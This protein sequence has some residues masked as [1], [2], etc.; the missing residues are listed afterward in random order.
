MKEITYLGETHTFSEWCR[1]LQEAANCEYDPKLR[2]FAE[3][4]RFEGRMTN[5]NLYTLYTIWADEKPI[6]KA[7]FEKRIPKIF[8]KYRPDIVPY[9][10]SSVRG[11]E[12]WDSYL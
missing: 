9:K 7:S 12:I 5:K 10:T 8:R 2:K 11:W 1:I 3:E 6:S 4:L